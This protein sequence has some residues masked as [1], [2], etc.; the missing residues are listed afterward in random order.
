MVLSAGGVIALMRGPLA[1]VRVHLA[2][3]LVA[4]IIG[5]FANIYSRL[6][7]SP[8]LIVII[9]AT[10]MIGALRLGGWWKWMQATVV[11]GPNQ[12]P[13]SLQHTQYIP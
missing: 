11:S 10:Y 1:D 4:F 12:S 3:Y 5:S 8:A 7:A 13:S 9:N 2:V 6:S